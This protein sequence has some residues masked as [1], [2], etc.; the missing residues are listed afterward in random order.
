LVSDLKPDHY[1]DM[2]H[3][4]VNEQLDAGEIAAVV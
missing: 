2:G 3:A 4:A 1:L